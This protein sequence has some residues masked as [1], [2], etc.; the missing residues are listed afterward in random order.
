MLKPLSIIIMLFLFTSCQEQEVTTNTVYKNNLKDYV[1]DKNLNYNQVLRKAL[2]LDDGSFAKVRNILASYRKNLKSKPERAEILKKNREKK[3]SNILNPSQL[4]KR[5]YVNAVYYNTV[6][7]YPTH[8][9][10][11]KKQF[12]LTDGQILK[13]IEIEEG[14]SQDKKKKQREERIS[15]LMGKK[16]AVQ[17]LEGKAIII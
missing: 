8:P 1:I 5:K 3:L 4:K 12:K 15:E 10:N 11:V 2:E 6:P 17:Y 16:N 14:F 7:K 9:A 13:L